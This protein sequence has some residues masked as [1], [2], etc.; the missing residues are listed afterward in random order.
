MKSIGVCV[1]WAD[2]MLFVE[3]SA[4][5]RINLT[6]RSMLIAHKLNMDAVHNRT[7]NDI[8][9]LQNNQP[10]CHDPTQ[11]YK[12]MNIQIKIIYR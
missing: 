9:I 8:Q 5:N 2:S 7:S 10:S 3:C 6:H 12:Q 1:K 11:K 4:T